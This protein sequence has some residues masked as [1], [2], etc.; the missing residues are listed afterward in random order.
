MRNP[1]AHPHAF[2]TPVSAITGLVEGAV[3]AALAD[4]AERSM[5]LVKTKASC[6]IGCLLEN[7]DRIDATQ[8]EPDALEQTA[9]PTLTAAPARTARPHGADRCYS[10]P[11]TGPHPA[12]LD[13]LNPDLAV[14]ELDTECSSR[15]H[16]ASAAH[17]R[18]GA[19]A[20]DRKPARQ[21]TLI[22]E[23]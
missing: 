3:G 1:R 17:H 13:R 2:V 18:P 16:T 12:I 11:A 19:I 21:H 20:Q 9:L 23:R 22:A 8:P 4:A 7:V 6:G 5:A 15:P 10:R 14:G